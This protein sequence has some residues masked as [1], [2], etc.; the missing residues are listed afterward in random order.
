V[1]GAEDPAEAVRKLRDLAARA[2]AWA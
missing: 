1:Y 2:R